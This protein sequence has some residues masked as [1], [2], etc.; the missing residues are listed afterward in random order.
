MAA[1]V[2]CAKRCLRAEAPAG[3]GRVLAYEGYAGGAAGVGRCGAQQQ[4]R[5]WNDD[6]AN[7]GVLSVAAQKAPAMECKREAPRE[8]DS[9]ASLRAALI[10]GD[11][12]AAGDG[13]AAAAAAPRGAWTQVWLC[14]LLRLWS[15]CACACACACARVCLLVV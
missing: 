15:A 12:R 13:G 2:T 1:C 8:F 6:E 3:A 14:I 10:A 11:A 4:Q 9:V 7:D 5:Q